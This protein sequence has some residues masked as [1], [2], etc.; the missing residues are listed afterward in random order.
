M[1][2]KDYSIAFVYFVCYYHT[3]N[4]FVKL[5]TTFVIASFAL[6]GCSTAYS[7]S[8]NMPEPTKDVASSQATLEALQ[9]ADE[10]VLKKK[11]ISFNDVYEVQADGVVVGEITGEYFYLLGDTFS[12]HNSEKNLVAYEGEKFKTFNHGAAIFDYNAEP[13]GALDEQLSFLV[14]S[15]DILDAQ[16]EKI[17]SAKQNFSLNLKFDVLNAAGEAEYKIEKAF[18]S[19][20][21]QLT[22]TRL[23]K[24]PQVPV[25]NA[26]WLA[27]IANEIAEAE[28]DKE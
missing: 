4:K 25:M 15:W 18:F 22:I 24:E 21:A 20:S 17:G 27:A 28:E 23:S 2:V 10:I 19:L 3:M 5:M 8:S 1:R 11:A 7:S 16:D 6:T 26:V 13:V 9:W 12:F 14:T